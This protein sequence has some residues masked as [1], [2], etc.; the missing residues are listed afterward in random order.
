MKAVKVRSSSVAMTLVFI[1]S[2]LFF[3]L[4]SKY[5]YIKH[6]DFVFEEEMIDIE[7]LKEHNLPIIILFA[8]DPYIYDYSTV[9]PLRQL[10]KTY[11]DKIIIKFVD[12]WK[13]PEGVGEFPVTVIP[14]W[15][16]YDAKGQP[17]QSTESKIYFEKY[18]DPV[19]GQHI[20]SLRRGLLPELESIIADMLS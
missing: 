7:E 16:F 14:T 19:N 6:P 12:V 17:Y 5:N 3:S 2:V 10:N 18:R 13:N 4:Y 9:W 11:Q 15:V 8:A 1:F 20:Y